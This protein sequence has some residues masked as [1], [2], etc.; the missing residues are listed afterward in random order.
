VVVS[1]DTLT[2]AFNGSTL[3]LTG[4]GDGTTLTL[5]GGTIPLVTAPRLE[6]L[7]N[8]LV[9]ALNAIQTNLLAHTHPLVTTTAPPVPDPQTVAL[10][11]PMVPAVIPP[12]DP[13]IP[14]PNILAHDDTP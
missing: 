9:I 2:V 3:A 4:N 6:L 5:G 14:S 8:Q 10:P 1:N 7:Y 11:A 13:L 12:W